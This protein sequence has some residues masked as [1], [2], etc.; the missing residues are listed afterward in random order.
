MAAAQ[1]ADRC[2]EVAVLDEV[3]DGDEDA[4]P[5]PAAP[6]HELWRS[7]PGAEKAEEREQASQD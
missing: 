3:P 2:H 5:P 1:L 6:R 7:Q 4:L